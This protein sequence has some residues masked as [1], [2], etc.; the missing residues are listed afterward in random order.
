V[1]L[2]YLVKRGTEVVADAEV[3]GKSVLF[4]GKAPESEVGLGR[5]R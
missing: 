3:E 4:V 5:F 1:L 2:A